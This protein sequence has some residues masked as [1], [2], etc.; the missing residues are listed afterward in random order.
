MQSDRP[1][2]WRLRTVTGPT[3]EPRFAPFRTSFGS[4][5]ALIGGKTDFQQGWAQTG[6]SPHPGASQ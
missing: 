6:R 3:D 5:G 1:G 4:S 2:E